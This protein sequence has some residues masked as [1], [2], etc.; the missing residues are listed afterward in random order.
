MWAGQRTRCRA[1]VATGE[2]KS[3]AGLGVKCSKEEPPPPEG[4]SSLP[5][6]CA[7]AGRLS[8]G[9][10][11]QSPYH[12][13]QGGPTLWLCARGLIPAPRGTGIISSPSPRHCC[14]WLALMTAT[15]SQGCTATLG[16]FAK[17]T[18]NAVPKTCSSLPPDLR[19]RLYSPSLPIRNSRTILERPTP[20]CLSRAPRLQLWLQHRL[21]YKKNK[22]NYACLKKKKKR[23]GR[24]PSF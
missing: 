2:A 21:L 5:S 17:A 7:C 20:G 15:P 22:A 1:C 10:D 24:V 3:C 18:F 8:G 12:A 4:P 6:H 19:K 11:Q 9:R 14:F 23:M 16:N 13:S